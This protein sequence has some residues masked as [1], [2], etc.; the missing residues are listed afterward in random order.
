M[1]NGLC[2]RD[3]TQKNRHTW[4]EQTLFETKGEGSGGRERKKQRPNRKRM[5]YSTVCEQMSLRSRS[6]E[7]RECAQKQR[8]V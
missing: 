2:E 5:S 6:Y 1:D 3:D 4:R 8:R 7:S